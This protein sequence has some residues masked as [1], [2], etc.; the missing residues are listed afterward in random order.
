M[1]RTG[2]IY[3]K[4]YNINNILDSYKEVMKTTRNKRY[5]TLF[6][7]YKCIYIKRI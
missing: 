7:R 2:D 3:S 5:I 6:N 1:K 4:L